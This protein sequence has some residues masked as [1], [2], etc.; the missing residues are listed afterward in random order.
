MPVLDRRR[1]ATPSAGVVLLVMCVGY[2]L[3]L[4]D[5]TIV[6][7]ALPTIGRRLH[8]GISGLQWVVDGYA[9][10]LAGVMLTGGT[11]GDVRGHKRVVLAGL[12]L[13]GVASL[14]C[15]L[16]GSA[17][18]L[19]RLPGHPGDRRGAHA[20][21]NARRHHQ[22]LSRRARSGSG[23][24][25]LG[26]R[27]KLR[28]ARRPPPGRPAR[29]GR[30]LALG[31]P[32]QRADC[33]RGLRRRR[34]GGGGEPPRHGTPAG[35]PRCRPGGACPRR[36]HL[37]V[38]RGR[39]RRDGAPGRHRRRVRRSGQ[40]RVRAGGRP[41][42]GSTAPARTAATDRLR[43]R[44][45]RRRCHESRHP[46]AAVRA[47]ALPPGGAPRWCAGGR[48]GPAAAVRPVVCPGPGGWAHRRPDRVAPADARRAAAGGG[49]GCAAHP[50]RSHHGLS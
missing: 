41:C 37:R 1:R 25:G 42:P 26:R 33:R 4:L 29:P 10:A 31:V 16:A 40:R 5:A 23:D 17:E 18:V 30:G 50:H 49:R 27:R 2:F 32:A 39:T 13:F 14:G 28:A 34:P 38:H 3:V 36:G 43:H 21:R 7:V 8:A 20:P 19:D 47:H 45:C 12:V 11:V 44:Q 9:L 22:C 15:G 48:A 46:R 24:R 6:N 35:S